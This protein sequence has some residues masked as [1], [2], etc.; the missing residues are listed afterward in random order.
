MSLSFAQNDKIDCVGI[1]QDYFPESGF[2]NYC[3]L[4]NNHSS[5][6]AGHYEIEKAHIN[7]SIKDKDVRGIYAYGNDWISV[8]PLKVHE[9]FPDIVDYNAASCSIDFVMY[10]HF[11][12]LGS[13]IQLKLSNNDLTQIG[14]NRGGSPFYDLKSLERLYLGML[15]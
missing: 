6:F 2:I 8:L 12:N 1:V 7:A 9:I 4:S 11:M 15:S 5:N 3:V 10:D 14:V 13:L